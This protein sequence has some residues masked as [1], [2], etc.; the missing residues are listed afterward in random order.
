MNVIIAKK[1]YIITFG[2]SCRFDNVCIAF[3]IFFVFIITGRMFLSQ[4]SL[5]KTIIT[6]YLPVSLK[7]T[8]LIPRTLLVLRSDVCQEAFLSISKKY[9]AIKFMELITPIRLIF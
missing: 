8:F 7:N 9:L 5:Q 6:V 2:I 1:P 3:Y 4:P